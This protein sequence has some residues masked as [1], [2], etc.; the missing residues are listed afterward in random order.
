LL[1]INHLR[2]QK[3]QFLTVALLLPYFEESE[4]YYMDILKFIE[5][6]QNHIENMC[7]ILDRRCFLEEYDTEVDVLELDLDYGETFEKLNYHDLPFVFLN[8]RLRFFEVKKE[9]GINYICYLLYKK[10][11]EI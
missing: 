9:Y 1:I 10:I 5:T 8:K 3:S 4:I 6:H 2:Y 7:I 11:I